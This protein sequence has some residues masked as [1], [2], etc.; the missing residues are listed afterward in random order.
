MDEGRAAG[1]AGT[2][3]ERGG[4]KQESMAKKRGTHGLRKRCPLCKHLRRFYEPPRNHGGQREARAGWV[5]VGS[6]WVCSC[7]KARWRQLYAD[8]VVQALVREV[9]AGGYR[10]CEDAEGDLGLTDEPAGP[11]PDHIMLEVAEMIRAQHPGV[12]VQ[13]GG[14]LC[15]K[16]GRRRAEM[17]SGFTL[18]SDLRGQYRYSLEL[19]L[20]MRPPRR[21]PCWLHTQAGVQVPRNASELREALLPVLDSSELARAAKYLTQQE[22]PA[23]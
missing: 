19:T 17:T 2:R 13:V 8:P 23:P 22:E 3:Q 5:K 21:Y 9:V 15:P 6:R 4:S 11:Y 12:E 7:V 20:V 16:Q 1:F 10:S 14:T 18:R